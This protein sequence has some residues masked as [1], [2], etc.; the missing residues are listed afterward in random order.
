LTEPAQRWL[1][2]QGL[3]KDFGAR[4]LKRAIQRYVES[5]LSMRLLKGE[6]KSG[7]RVR[8]DVEDDQLTFALLESAPMPQPVE[9][10]VD[11]M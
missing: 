5:A 11:S 2:Q 8:I 10:L 1:A 7:D 4:P 6:F 9:E 3:D